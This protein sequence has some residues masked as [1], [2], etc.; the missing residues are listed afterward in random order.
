[1][2][3]S[4]NDAASDEQERIAI[5]NLAIFRKNKGLE[6]FS[7]QKKLILQTGSLLKTS[8][9]S[10]IVALTKGTASFGEAIKSVTGSLTSFILKSFIEQQIASRALAIKQIIQAK[11]VASAR[12]IAAEA[13]K[14]LLG[15]ATASIAVAAFSALISRFANF[16]QGGEVT[17]RGGIDSVPALLTPGERVLTP[18]QNRNFKGGGATSIVV[19]IFD[20]VVDSDDRL[21]ELAD[22][23]GSAF[24]DKLLLEGRLAT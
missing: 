18:A 13:S 23:V 24:M 2:I 7:F 4:V 17:G 22:R 21:S 1:M 12:A 14:G 19:N 3:K 20:P 11:G 15:I 8:I 6:V 16:Q 9:A 5:E 10:N